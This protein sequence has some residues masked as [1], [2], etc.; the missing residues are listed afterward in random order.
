MGKRDVHICLQINPG[1]GRQ[2]KTSTCQIGEKR[3]SR[4]KEKK[5]YHNMCTNAHKPEKKPANKFI[6]ELVEAD[7][8]FKVTD[9][10]EL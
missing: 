2:N 7:I 10:T 6:Q 8:I 1:Q 3:R 9:T 4:T 5:E